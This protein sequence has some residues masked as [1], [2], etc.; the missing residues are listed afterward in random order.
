MAIGLNACLI[1]VA[2]TL[3]EFDALLQARRARAPRARGGNERDDPRARARARALARARQVG[4]FLV[5]VLEP[6]YYSLARLAL[7]EAA[8]RER[9]A[10]RA[11]AA[12]RG[13]RAR[14]AY[15]AERAAVIAAQMARPSSLS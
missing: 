12:V 3:L 15:R 2:T 9:A 11:Q 4:H 6:L 10:T 7:A 13:M 1:S 8:R 14:A 5:D